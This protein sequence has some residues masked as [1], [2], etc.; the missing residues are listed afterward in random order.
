[1]NRKAVIIWG[2]S[3]AGKTSTIKHLVGCP[4][5]LNNRIFKI[6]NIKEK[7]V[8]VFVL[9][10]SPSEKRQTLEELIKKN[11]KKETLPD[12]IIVTEQINGKNAGNTI[13]FLIKNKYQITFFVINNPEKHNR[14]HWDY[15]TDSMPSESVFKKRVE[16]IKAIF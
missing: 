14:T 1:M 9:G 16:D 11:Y 15:N 7:D 6:K 4:K 12:K 3:N 8:E 5:R 13:N 2:T 10:Q